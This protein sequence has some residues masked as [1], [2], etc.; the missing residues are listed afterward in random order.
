MPANVGAGGLQED[1]NGDLTGYRAEPRS[2][3]A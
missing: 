3:A 2:E 1:P